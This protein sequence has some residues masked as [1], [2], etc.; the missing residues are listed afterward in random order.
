MNRF[1]MRAILIFLVLMICFSP[2]CQKCAYSYTTDTEVRTYLFLTI[3]LIVPVFV[4]GQIIRS[5][6]DHDFYDKDYYAGW[7]RQSDTDGLIS[8]EAGDVTNTINE[9]SVYNGSFSRKMGYIHKGIPVRVIAKRE[10]NGFWWLETQGKWYW[11]LFNKG[12]TFDI[13]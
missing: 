5:S 4:V 3:V 10:N 6:V 9:T 13:N 2:I 8:A 7:I 11:V 12:G 1:K